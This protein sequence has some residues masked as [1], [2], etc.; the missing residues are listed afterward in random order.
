MIHAPVPS[1]TTERVNPV[2]VCVAVTVTPGSTAPLSSVTFPASSAVACAQATPLV[3]NNPNATTEKL[4]RQRF[5]TQPSNRTSIA[6]PLWSAEMATRKPGRRYCSVGGT[7]PGASPLNSGLVSPT[8]VID[9]SWPRLSTTM[10]PNASKTT[11][12][13]ANRSFLFHPSRV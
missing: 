2:S 7:K 10:P 12:S 8:F 4:R 1:V 6:G 5:I 13:P 11:F 3:S 9:R